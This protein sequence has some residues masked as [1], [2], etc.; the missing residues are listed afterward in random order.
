MTAKEVLQKVKSIFNE[1]PVVAAA[2]VVPP[3]PP[4]PVG[5]TYKLAD[6]TEISIVQ[7][8]ELPAPGDVVS[9]GGVP[10]PAGELVLED[11]STVV[12]GEAGVISE[13]KP[14]EPVTQDIPV[15]QSNTPVLLN[16]ET[17]QA[18]YAKFATGTPEERIANLELMVKAL[19]EC[20]FGYQIRQGQENE[21]IQ[22]YKDSLATT[23]ATVA[24]QATQ[25]QASTEKIEKQD[26]VIEGLFELAE[27]LAETPTAEP[28]T[29]TGNKKG[30]F[31]RTIAK[32]KKIEGIASAITQLKNKNK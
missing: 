10:A 26:K 12:V 16:A 11:G 18:M 30:Q 7:A 17:V 13:V 14:V 25:L 24:Q 23:Q 31:E 1:T 28:K 3:A 22:A 4:A 20:N 6:G 27:K 9:V 21:A 8:G 29:L 15:A 32:E 5:T 19:M 2:P